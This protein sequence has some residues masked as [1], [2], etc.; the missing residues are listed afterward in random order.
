[1]LGDISPAAWPGKTL[2]VMWMRC[3][4]Q[5]AT[6]ERMQHSFFFFFFFTVTVYSKFFCCFVCSV[7]ATLCWLG[8]GC[9]LCTLF[10]REK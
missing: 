10:L 2:L 5:T 7:C 1:M 6:E 4:G 8:M 9:T 3:C